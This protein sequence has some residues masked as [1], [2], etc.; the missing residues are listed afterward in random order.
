MG[1]YTYTGQ[2]DRVGVDQ[3]DWNQQANW[4]PSIPPGTPA[5]VINFAAGAATRNVPDNTP[6]DELHLEFGSQ[7]SGGSFIVGSRLEI[8]PAV[9]I[10][11]DI[12]SNGIGTVDTASD[13]SE[14][15]SINNSHKLTNNGLLTVTGGGQFVLGGGTPV[16]IDNKGTITFENAGLLW[17]GGSPP[18]LINE[19]TMTIVG[20]CL[21]Q[22]GDILHSGHL[23]FA[24]GTLMVGDQTNLHLQGGDLTG[25]GTLV[26]GGSGTSSAF[27]TLQ[28]DTTLPDSLALEVRAGAHVVFSVAAG[29][30]EPAL[31]I[32]RSLL[33]AGDVGNAYVVARLILP[34]RATLKISGM[35][36][37][38][39]TGDNQNGSLECAGV[40]MVQPGGALDI[41]IGS[42]FLNTGRVTL[43]DTGQITSLASPGLLDNRGMLEKTGSGTA[44]LGSN[45]AN[46][47]HIVVRA[48]VLELNGN[49]VISDGDLTL[50]GGNLA[51][52]GQLILVG[53]TTGGA[54][55]GSGSVA[56]PVTNGGWV[57]PATSG[58]TLSQSY[59]QKDDGNLIVSKVD[60]AQ[61]STPLSVGG[62]VTLAGSLWLLEDGA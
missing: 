9:L 30:A 33:L 19:G 17:T 20:G 8:A 42:T 14:Y 61:G 4:S 49:T 40:T 57:E 38:L 50:A 46:D 58:M 56:V 36:N 51:G 60:L 45:V 16:A 29:A 3:Y 34:T 39:G 2:G 44:S 23:N 32:T 54:L 47:G 6:A 48:G 53:G 35:S 15:P 27:L 13:S 12:T 7:I 26:V 52:G 55:R 1:T 10:N 25:S 22:S 24:D 28:V 5:D 41:A 11:T 31:T 62:S 37:L 43:S 18:Q 21:F 59:V